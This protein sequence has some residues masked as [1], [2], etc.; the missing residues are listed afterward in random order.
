MGC[1]KQHNL[2]CWNCYCIVFTSNIGLQ[3]MSTP[4]H[5]VSIDE[6]VLVYVP[7]RAVSAPSRDKGTKRHFDFTA[8]FANFTMWLGVFVFEGT[9]RFQIL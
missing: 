5:E 6:I 9:R 4:T 3:C 1:R 2:I 7:L 8:R